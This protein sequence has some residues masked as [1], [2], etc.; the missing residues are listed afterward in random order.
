ME[1][2]G[3]ALR[4]ICVEWR[5]GFIRPN[6]CVEAFSCENSELLSDCLYALF[7]APHTGHFHVAGSR[8]NVVFLVGA[9]LA[10]LHTCLHTLHA[11]VSGAGAG[12][13]VRLCDSSAVSGTCRLSCL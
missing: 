13:A 9:S 12:A 6:G 2:N 5:T 8:S 4:R 11:Q 3:S 1:C 10:G 7:G